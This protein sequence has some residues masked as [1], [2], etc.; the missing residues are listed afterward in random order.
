MFL[1]LEDI[2]PNIQ[3]ASSVLKTDEESQALNLNLGTLKAASNQ[4]CGRE[5][6]RR[7]LPGMFH[8]LAIVGSYWLLSFRPSGFQAVLIR[9][10]GVKLQKWRHHVACSSWEITDQLKKTVHNTI[11]PGLC[12]LNSSLFKIFD[13]HSLFL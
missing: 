11:T 8:D 13:I 10:T 5:L 12:C 1:D 4:A 9:C 6:C 2:K 7:Y 3:E